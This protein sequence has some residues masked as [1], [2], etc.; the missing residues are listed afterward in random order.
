MKNYLIS[1]F[2]SYGYESIHQLFLSLFP[3]F[4]YGLQGITL[5]LSI[6][7]AVTNAIFGITP[8]VALMMVVAIIVETATGIMASK[9]RNEPFESWK[10][11]RCIL[12]V[13]IWLCILFMVNIL[14]DNFAT[15]DGW[16]AALAAY[17]FTFVNVLIL[18][19]FCIEYIT[20]ILENF[21]VLDGK[22]KDAFIKAIQN[23]WTS[24]LELFQKRP[25]L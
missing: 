3:S 17:F 5:T 15:K 12:K 9:K 10:F 1:L 8:Y 19:Y 20:S 25:K 4:K 14:G 6:I 2:G 24:F 22:P 13:G 21:A 16:I 18:V 11:S 7:G 23:S